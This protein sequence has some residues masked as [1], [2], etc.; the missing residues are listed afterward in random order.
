[1]GGLTGKIASRLLH[2]AN[3]TP[4]TT[5]LETRKKIRALPRGAKQEIVKKKKSQNLI[6]HQRERGHGKVRL[7]LKKN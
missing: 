3:V 1:L 6:T 5:I 4:A 7:V 2:N